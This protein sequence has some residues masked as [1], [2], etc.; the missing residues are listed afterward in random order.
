MTKNKQ[1]IADRLAALREEMRRENLS[2]FIFPSSDPHMSE[3]VP[4]RWEGR[5]WISGFDGSAGTAV[6]TLHSAALWTDSR[7]FIAAEEQLEGTEFQLMRERVDSTPSIPEWISRELQDGDSTEIGVDGMCMPLA[8]AEDMK[9]ALRHLGGITMRTNLDILERVWTDR[10]SVPLN[11]VE[12]HS[13]E[14]AGESVA[15]KL[16]RIRHELLCLGA[17][18]MLMTQLDDI[19]WTLNLRGSDVHCTPVFVAWLIVAEDTAVL[20][21]KDEKLSPEVKDYLHNE[22]IAIDDYDNI[23]DALNS[24]GGY[25]LLIDPATTNCTLAQLRGNFNAVNAP[26]PVPAMKAVKNKVEC[27]GY[28]NAMLRDGVAL[29]KFLK[30]LDEAVPRGKETEL[31]VSEKLRQ[32]RSEQKLFRD[33][34][35]DT[36]AGYEEHGAIVH[37]EPTPDT[38]VPLRPDGFLLL[39]SGAQ[40]SDGTTDITRTIQLGPV[41]DL[42]RRVYTLVLKGHLSLQNLCFPR[43]AAGTQLDAVARTAMW[44]EGMNFMH[45]T[46]HGVGSYLSVHEGPH[47]IRQ[48]Y[49]PAPMLEGMTVTDEPGLYLAGKFGVRIENVLLTVPY[50]TTEF[51]SFLRFEPLT[52]CPIDTQPI[53]VDMLTVEERRCLNAYH[54][55]VYQ[56]LAPLLDSD[57]RE[58]LAGKTEAI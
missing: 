49:R 58:W 46:G 43:G 13:M 51:G 34:S 48:E 40:Y 29:V 8:E 52:L 44:R 5:K 15:D 31:S 12:I 22:G 35:F 25:S 23:I 50:M 33:I 41:S 6:V 30:W 14:F 1:I 3:Y 26:S 10:P 39:D 42:H 9:A 19:A 36:I 57:E 20:F 17:G 28:R 4:S 54:E 56:R 7:Y 32:L 27:D 38:D 18:G 16:S 53:L 37:Y 45:G 11:P 2:A 21:I 55:M 24:Y 47:Q